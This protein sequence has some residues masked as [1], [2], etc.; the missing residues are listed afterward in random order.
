MHTKERRE[1]PTDEDIRMRMNFTN[2]SNNGKSKMTSGAIIF[3][4][5]YAIPLIEEI[6][7]LEQEITELKLLVAKYEERLEELEK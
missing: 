1:L 5:E 3:R 6:E 7:K 2:N 4:N